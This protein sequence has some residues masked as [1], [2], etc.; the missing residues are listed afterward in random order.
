MR[1][2]SQY[3]CN[4]SGKFF[5]LTSDKYV[6]NIKLFLSTILQV[7][8]V[9]KL[10]FK[11]FENK[12][13]SIS[14]LSALLFVPQIYFVHSINF[15]FQKKS[16]TKLTATNLSKI[17]SFFKLNIQVVFKKGKVYHFQFSLQLKKNMLRDKLKINRKKI[18]FGGLVADTD[19]ILQ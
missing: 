1:T 7:I 5:C 8:V 16:V 12:I 3:L 2:F 17:E 19:C 18:K 4:Y 13:L 15:L 14:Y 9:I 10:K 11:L 6:S